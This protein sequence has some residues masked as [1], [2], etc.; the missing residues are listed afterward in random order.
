MKIKYKIAT[1]FSVVCAVIIGLTGIFLYFLFADNLEDQFQDRLLERAIIAGEVLLEKDEF[2]S[3]KYEAIK[4]RYL[5]NLSREEVYYVYAE[6]G[7]V[8]YTTVPKKFRNRRAIETSVNKGYSYFKQ[9]DLQV[10]SLFYQDN[11]GDYIILLAARDDEGAAQLVFLRNALLGII[12]GGIL[13]IAAF[14]LIFAK[15]I[16]KPINSMITKVQGISGSN[17]QA[18]L[19]EG[20]GKD[21]ISRL[22]QTF[23]GMLSRLE[24]SFQTQKSFIHN[25]S[26]ELRTPLTVILGE[27]EYALKKENLDP[28][29]KLAF[30]KIFQEADHLRQL[31]NS[32]LQLSEMKNDN[33]KT[34]FKILRIDELVQQ[35]VIKMNADLEGANIKLE[36]GNTQ[37]L[38][39]GSYEILG[40]EI[41][42]E[43]AVTNV[44][45]NAI[46]YSGNKP[47]RVLLF[48][49]N[50][51]VN[52]Q[53]EDKG[54]GINEKE[55][56]KIFL[57]FYR[58]Q[59]VRPKKGYGIGLTLTKNI[60][61]IHK[62]EILIKSIE[63]QGSIVLVQLPRAS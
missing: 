34:N 23:N 31:L 62:G 17:L 57:P 24:N 7:N 42:M 18:R 54:I 1:L 26:H 32:L 58:G 10:C 13:F 29:Q 4:A 39:A 46:K 27:A 51:M 28:E 55:L 61:K 45:N 12:L 60:I 2:S 49:Q 53:F 40:N 52:V 48:D 43:I 36:Y 50:G 22:A 15:H 8:D 56:D 3:R 47:V 5:Q 16:L 35:V 21:E 14:S 44:L 9:D 30:K 41:W 38:T 63:K 59:N 11:E 19:Y 20:K 37:N 25:A 6:E 33:L